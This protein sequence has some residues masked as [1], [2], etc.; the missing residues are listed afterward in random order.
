MTEELSA[1]EGTEEVDVTTKT[2]DGREY[3]IDAD[4]VV[5]DMTTQEPIG[6]YDEETGR[7]TSAN[8]RRRSEPNRQKKN[9][10]ET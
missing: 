7:S 6:V 9:R 5:Y 4:N 8:L 10:K 3:L 1:E 2:I